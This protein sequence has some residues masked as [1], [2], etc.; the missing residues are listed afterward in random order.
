MNSQ[1]ES[2]TPL[3]TVRQFAA[4]HPAFT[5]SSL[6]WLIFQSHSRASSK[7][8]IPGNGLHAALLRIGRRVLI[9]ETRFFEWVAAQQK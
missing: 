1:T 3:L 5:E 9:D 6:R 4:R 7:G 8:V 2:R